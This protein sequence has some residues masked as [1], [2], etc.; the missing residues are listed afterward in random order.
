MPG[1]L[2]QATNSQSR[3]LGPFLDSVDFLTA[4]TGLTIANT[5]IKIV[6]NGGASANKNSGGGTHRVNGVY[7]VTFDATDTATVGEMEVSV[8]VAGALPVFD[9]FFVVEEAVY[10]ALFAAS[11]PGYLQPTTAGRTLDV[12]AGG[13]AGV[14]WANVGSP[15]TSL[16]LTGTTIATTQ[17]VDVETIKTNAVV[18]GGTVTFPTGAT[19]ASTTNITAGTI[20]T[21]TNLTNAP[22]AGDFTA[23]MKTSIGTAVAASAVASVT[24][25]VGGSVAS[26]ASGGITAASFGAGAINAAAIAT[27]AIDADAIKTD[28]VTE[29]QAGLATASVL[30][31]VK[32][33]T[34]KLDSTLQDDAGSPARYQFTQDAL[35]NLLDVQ[36]SGH[37]I[38]GSAGKAITDAQ[39]A[40]DPWAGQIETGFTYGDAMK[41]MAAVAAGKTVIVD[42]GGGAASITF[43]SIDDSADR[44]VATMTDSERSAVTLTP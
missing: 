2:R 42:L 22:T 6:V 20:T 21:A 30:T 11:A 15:T 37:Q 4:K 5:D 26:V 18:N 1:Y 25:N 43:R 19:L 24:G 27:D 36:T 29:I 41:I 44:V 33:V 28:A 34:D 16:A 35:E 39:S 12:S 23:T 38:A 32:A 13:E 31:L 40:G 9:K 14:D 3:A 17:K 7:G 8:V 10:D